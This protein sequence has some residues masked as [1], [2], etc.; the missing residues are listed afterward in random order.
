[1][2]YSLTINTVGSGSVA[3]SPNQS[4]YSLGASVQLTATPL[5]GWVF[6]SWSG[7][8]TGSTNPGTVIID[9]DPSVT[10]T[11]VSG[12]AN[13]PPVLA[14]IGNQSGDELTLITFDADATDPD[15]GDTLTFSLDPGYPS[16]ASINSGTGVFTWTPTEAQDGDHSITVRVTDNGSPA[17]DDYETINVHVNE[18]AAANQPPVLGSIGDKTV[19]ELSLLTFDADATDP[20]IGD[21][22]TFSLQGTVP[23]GASI[24]SGTGVFTWTPTEAQGPGSYPIT[25]R[26]TDNGSPNL[27]DEEIITVTVNEVATTLLNDGFEAAGNAWDDNWDENG[28]TSWIQSNT[29]KHGGSYSARSDSSHEG[30]IYSDD[31]N[32]SG[33]TSVTVSFWFYHSNIDTDDLRLYFFDGSTTDTIASLGNTG[34]DNTWEYY[35]YTTTDTQYFRN[36]FYI[37][38]RTNNMGYGDQVYIDDVLITKIP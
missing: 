26:V 7:D 6:S 31:L 33:A 10:A 24:N 11:F 15:V 37:R 16:G 29:Q 32:T 12:T 5:A 38:I 34:S 36:D 17:L 14:A 23:P 18:V 28:G 30:S 3:K 20:D 1:V 19:D 22:L 21:T 9:A 35:T 13:Q 8:L 2:T 4:S 25:V 27:Y